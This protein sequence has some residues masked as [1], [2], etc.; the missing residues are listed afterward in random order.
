[1]PFGPDDSIPTAVRQ[2]QLSLPLETGPGWA[3]FV[4]TTE[5]TAHWSGNPMYSAAS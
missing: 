3:L 5:N 1:M 2:L 4:F